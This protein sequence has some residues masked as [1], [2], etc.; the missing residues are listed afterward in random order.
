MAFRASGDIARLS[1]LLRYGVSNRVLSEVICCITA[2]DD[3]KGNTTLLILGDRSLIQSAELLRDVA[4]RRCLSVRL[5]ELPWMRGEMGCSVRLNVTKQARS[6]LQLDRSGQVTLVVCDLRS[7]ELLGFVEK[8]AALAASDG[9][10]HHYLDVLGDQ[11]IQIMVSKGEYPDAL[12]RRV[13]RS[14]RARQSLTL[15]A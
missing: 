5:D 2:F 4:E 3:F 15:T 1:G 12:H 11:L 14:P 8:V 9:T 7:E 6:A 10:G 13:A